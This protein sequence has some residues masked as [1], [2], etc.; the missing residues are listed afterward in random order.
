[1]KN[2]YIYFKWYNIIAEKL[3]KKYPKK[4]LGCLAYAALSS[5]PEGS[6]KLHKMI[7]PYLTRDSAQL[8]DKHEIKEFREVIDKWS[9]IAHRMGIYEYI[10]GQGY[11]IPRIFNR[12]ILKNIKDQYGVGCDGFYA[13]AYPL[14]RLDAPKYYFIA[15]LLWN[16]NYSIKS[17][18][19][20]YYITCFGP[21]GRTM[22]N[23]FDFLEE[24]WCTQTLESGKSNYRWYQN[25]KQL[26]IFPPDKCDEAFAFLDKAEKILKDKIA[27][28]DEMQQELLNNNLMRVNYFREGLTVTRRLSYRYG[29]NADIMKNFDEK[30]LEFTKDLFDK[31]TL[32]SYARFL[33]TGSARDIYADAVRMKFYATKTAPFSTFNYQWNR[34]MGVLYF[35]YHATSSI[36]DI[37]YMM[38]PDKSREGIL[39]G[40][41]TALEKLKADLPVKDELLWKSLERDAKEKAFVYVS[42]S[43]S[44]SAPKIDGKINEN[45]WGE[46]FFTGHLINADSVDD[47]FPYESKFYIKLIKGKEDSLAMAFDCIADPKLMSGA[48]KPGDKDTRFSP[49]MA[50]D[51][52]VAITLKP[53]SGPWTAWR[54]NINGAFYGFKG[55]SKVTKND[56]GWQ[57]ELIVPVKK[58]GINLTGLMM[59][60]GSLSMAVARY[61]K[62]I[63]IDYR[64]R[65]LTK[66]AVGVI[67][68]TH[69]AGKT[70]GRGNHPAHMVF[71][72]GQAM[73]FEN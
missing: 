11:F 24:V 70:V 15:K 16:K 41:D 36:F 47:K 25:N 43:S 14:W 19:K 62:F 45:E 53:R 73:V 44:G 66:T 1:M 23:Y 57:L 20:D 5:L 35:M 67:R 13:E 34:H 37:G 42:K 48:I 58:A 29:C 63:Q 3:Y 51:S 50:K 55:K 8:F 9:R 6:I 26:E 52:A 61:E 7:V 39:K 21:A 18:E 17:L 33:S 27:S 31:D 72:W 38:T 10:Y 59:T 32:E 12:Y 69:R 30:K 54:F 46:P 28:A 2:S 22:K 49:K 71:I 56:K 4:R 64:K 68:P 65:K 60:P 40:I